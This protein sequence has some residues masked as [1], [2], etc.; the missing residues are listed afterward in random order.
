MKILAFLKTLS[1]KIWMIGLAAVVL[2]VSLLVLPAKTVA[3]PV[4]LSAYGQLPQYG[5]QELR[6]WGQGR[7]RLAD[8]PLDMDGYRIF[9]YKLDTEILEEYIALLEQNGFTLV[10]EHHQSSF[11]GSYQAYGLICDAAGDVETR[12]MMYTDTP[13][14]VSIWKADFKWRVE[15]CDGITLCDLGLRYD[16]SVEPVAPQGDSIGAGLRRSGST[17]KTDDGR[18]KTKREAAAVRRDGTEETAAATWRR[19]GARIY[20]TVEMADDLVLEICFREEEVQ[21]GEIYLLT[22]TEER[23]VTVTLTAGKENISADQ[24]GYPYFH[25]INLRFMYLGENG[26]VVLYLYAQP[27]DT[28]TYPATLELLCAV[29]TTPEEK[30][31]GSG[32]GGGWWND[33]DE[34]FQP[35]HSKLDCLTCRGDGNCTTCGGD[36]YTG[37][38]DA[39]AGCRSCHGNGNCTACGGSGKR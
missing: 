11:L 3:Q 29:N 24:T 19:S 36:G 8:E 32:S 9:M 33:D 6:A 2:L 22:S 27:M 14:H 10:D 1:P 35:N 20:V 17:F 21:Q 37:F 18:L 26:D 16:G 30:E 34:P 15:V 5:A 23:P 28:E 12:D 31:E 13:C 7:V 38:G 25:T 4:D 39:K